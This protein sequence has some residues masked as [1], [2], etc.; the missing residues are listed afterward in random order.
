LRDSLSP[1]ESA[2]SS[3]SSLDLKA[4]HAQVVESQSQESTGIAGLVQLNLS[5]EE[6]L[7]QAL[8]IKSLLLEQVFSIANEEPQDI[9]ALLR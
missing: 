3:Q 9:A 2:S 4:R 6:A 7:A 1:R 5:V 8:Q